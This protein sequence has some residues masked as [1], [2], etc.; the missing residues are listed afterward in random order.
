MTAASFAL[1]KAVVAALSTALA[2]DVPVFDRVPAAA[3]P[4]P[5]VV[6]GEGQELPNLA[7]C[8]NGREHYLDIHVWSR[9]VGQGEAKTIAGLVES[10]LHDADLTLEGHGLD[11]IGLNGIRYLRDPDGRTTH[12][13]LTFRALTQP[14]T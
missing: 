2:P 8:M 14:D 11:L 7:D 12:A 13:V 4:Y 1:Q 3:D 10:A 9:S 5:R 6:V